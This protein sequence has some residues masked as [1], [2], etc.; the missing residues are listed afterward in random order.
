MLWA[1]LHHD[2]RQLV[3]HVFLNS[4]CGFCSLWGFFADDLGLDRALGG[5]GLHDPFSLEAD[6]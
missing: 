2:I 5:E 3:V 6:N 1:V 4:F